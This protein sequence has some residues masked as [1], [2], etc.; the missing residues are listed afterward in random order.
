MSGREPPVPQPGQEKTVS[1]LLGG[2]C[3]SDTDCCHS[4]AVGTSKVVEPMVFGTS[5]WA[6]CR[7]STMAWR[8]G[9]R[10]R[11]CRGCVPGYTVP[12][13][14]GTSA[15]GDSRHSAP[16]RATLG[17]TGADRFVWVCKD[18]LTPAPTLPLSSPPQMI[19]WRTGYPGSQSDIELA[20]GGFSHT[21]PQ[22]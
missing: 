12:S 17:T 7:L 2:V 4:G 11:E 13:S 21:H 18:V 8:D 10:F 9:V 16:K 19:D 14:A 20:T 15:P 1:V 3:G 22:P 6:G 5:W